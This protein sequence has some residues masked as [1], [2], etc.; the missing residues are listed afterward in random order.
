MNATPGPA[1]LAEGLVKHYTGKEG[2]V[3][4]VRGVDLK[5]ATGEIFGF[6]GPNG[7]G[8]SATV[9]MLTTLL[10]ITAGSAHVAGG[11]VAADP[12]A[13]RRPGRGAPAHRRPPA[14][15]R[16]RRPPDGPRA[17]RPAGPPLRDVRRRRRRPRG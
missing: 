16:P 15:G 9:R 17:A 11:D 13:A 1:I 6:L 4:A 12:D 14:G 10:S 3:E 2:T 8:K 5:V 7:A